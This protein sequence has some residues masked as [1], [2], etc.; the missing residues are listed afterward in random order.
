MAPSNAGR[1]ITREEQLVRQLLNELIRETRLLRS[2]LKTFNISGKENL[3]GLSRIMYNLKT[4]SGLL[5]RDGYTGSTI[6]LLNDYISQLN[7]LCP[8]GVMFPN[9][10]SEIRERVNI[11]C[12]KLFWLHANLMAKVDELHASQDQRSH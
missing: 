10:P 11:G 8:A 9:T 2:F 3:V 5:G 12:A 4:V 1:H 7:R 6:S